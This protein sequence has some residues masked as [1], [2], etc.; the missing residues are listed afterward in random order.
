MSHYKYRHRVE[1]Q[2]PVDVQD[3]ETGAMTRTWATVYLDSDTPLDSVPAE[4]L[5][6]PGREMA[7][8]G[9]KLAETMA[10][11]HMRWFPGLRPDMRIIWEGQPMDIIS[12]ETDATARREYWAKVKSGITDGA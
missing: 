12:I 11:V 9:T 3:S 1:I 5:T 10:R 2:E 7:A 6:G 4:V 8:A